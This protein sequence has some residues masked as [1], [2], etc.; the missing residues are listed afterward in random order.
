MEIQ[1]TALKK[2]ER[3]LS[4]DDLLA[5]VGSAKAAAKLIEKVHAN[6]IGFA[7][8]IEL[9]DVKGIEKINAYRTEVLVKY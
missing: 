4:C 5:I 3:V 6:V 2:K 9:P 7:F 1:T 8:I